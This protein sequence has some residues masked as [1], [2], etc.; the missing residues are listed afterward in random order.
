[1]SKKKIKKPSLNHWP[2]GF[3]VKRKYGNSGG[4]C[5]YGAPHADGG[6][7]APLV[8]FSNSDHASKA[9]ADLFGAAP[10]LLAAC[11]IFMEWKSAMPPYPGSMGEKLE[12]AM[13]KALDKVAGKDTAT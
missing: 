11:E 13:K 7:F 5:V 4:W 8:D 2:Q 1:M 9:L 10:D 12:I 6:D 3:R